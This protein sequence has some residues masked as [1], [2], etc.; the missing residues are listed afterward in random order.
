MLKLYNT[1]AKQKEEFKP[2]HPGKVGMYSCGPTVYDFAHIGNLK[3]YISTDILRR[4]LEYSG[5]EVRQIMN[6]TDVGHLTADDVNQADTGEDKMLKGAEREKKTPQEVAEFY[7]EKFF[8]DLKKLN[9]EKSAYYPRATAHIPQMIK[10]IE[11]L[12]KKELAYEVNGNVFY[13]VEKFPSYG[14]LSGIKLEEL[15]AGARLEEHPDKKHPYDFSLWLKAPKNHIL[16]WKS[17]WSL[18]YPGWHIECTA[19]S[20]EYLGETL[21]IHT[22][23]EDHIFPHHENE[24]AQSEGYTGKT[25]SNY[26]M[27]NRFLLVDGQ[28]MS[29]SKGNF[30]A[31]RDIEDKKY[32]PMEFR[33][34]ALSAHYR[35]NVNFTWTAM[36]QAK[37]NF[38]K[39]VEWKTNLQNLAEK[40]EDKKSEIDFSHIYQKRFEEAMD[41]DLNTPLALSV[42]YEL[43]TETNK[44]MVENKLS[45]ETAKNILNFWEKINKIFG[46]IIKKERIDVSQDIIKL[47][48]ERKEARK[49]GD[50]QKS[51]ELRKEIEEKGYIIED[52]K[53]NEY[54]IKSK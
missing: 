50:F 27:H 51:D 19:M 41:D 23:G 13:S 12:I 53:D 52:L 40:A 8:E 30:Y 21:D 2:I 29:K 5:Y 33:M 25:F 10:I 14:K 28:K 4:F 22:G 24:I 54:K 7:T 35:S 1:L 44:L 3:T 9:I 45:E 38:K 42:L 31:L 36:D 16:K 11:A 39:I 26:W 20:I 6:I 48:K 46:L 34:L 32:S 18:G 49:A 37:T 43:I 47:A 15:K 17:P